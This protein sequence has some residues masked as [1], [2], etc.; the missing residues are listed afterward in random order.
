MHVYKYSSNLSKDNSVM[1]RM[2]LS[3]AKSTREEVEELRLHTIAF[4]AEVQAR[5][6]YPTTCMDLHNTGHWNETN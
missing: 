1:S 5:K 3:S 4:Y 6:H 2:T